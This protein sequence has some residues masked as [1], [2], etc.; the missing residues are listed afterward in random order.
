MNMFAMMV[1]KEFKAADKDGSGAID[2]NE[3]KDVLN[4]LSKDLK[5]AQVTDEDVNNYLV[6]LDLEE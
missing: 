4:K 3:L 6:K 2:K 5:L 1:E